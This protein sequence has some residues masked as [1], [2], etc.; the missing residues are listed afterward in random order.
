MVDAS[1]TEASPAFAYAGATGAPKVLRTRDA[2][3]DLSRGLIEE[4]LAHLRSICTKTRTRAAHRH[5]IW[6][7][8]PAPS[9]FRRRAVARSASRKWRRRRSTRP[10]YGHNFAS[11]RFLVPC[12]VDYPVPPL[13]VYLLFLAG[14]CLGICR[15][16]FN[17][18]STLKWYRIRPPCSCSK[19]QS[20]NQ[21]ASLI[22]RSYSGTV[23]ECSQVLHRG[24]RCSC[25]ASTTECWRAASQSSSPPARS[26]YPGNCFPPIRMNRRRQVIRMTPGAAV[27]GTWSAYIRTADRLRCILRW[28]NS[29]YHLEA[30]RGY[31]WYLGARQCSEFQFRFTAESYVALPASSSSS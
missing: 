10:P 27:L 31:R 15:P 4:S 23:E 14:Q 3:Q 26:V 20:R 30:A 29:K 22:L 16:I 18:N 1:R 8:R 19:L 2:T 7:R 28:W 25:G 21:W 17:L 11:L 12:R 6:Q 24:A 9:C 5:C 13:I